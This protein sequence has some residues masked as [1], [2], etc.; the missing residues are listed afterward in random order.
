[1]SRVKKPNRVKFKVEYDDFEE[2]TRL[3]N[4]KYTYS[5]ITKL[6]GWSSTT[7]RT[8]E[9][10]DG[11]YK[12]YRELIIVK[13]KPTNLKATNPNIF[14]KTITDTEEPVPA[15]P[16]DDNMTLSGITYIPDWKTIFPFRFKDEYK[17]LLFFQV[18][19]TVIV[20]FGSNEYIFEV[21]QETK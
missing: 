4:R 3:L 17:T 10:A 18:S 9:K 14:Y 16:Q 11:D 15:P 6:T 5:Q 2:I 20:R 12:K 13:A 8:A 19:N 1:M 21:N 7:V